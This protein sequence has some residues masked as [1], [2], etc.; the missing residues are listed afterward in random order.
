[1]RFE[2]LNDTKIR[3][4]LTIQDMESNNISFENV[5]SNST[6]SQKLLESMISKAEKEIGFYAE[7]SKLLVEAIM[8]S[9]KECVF[10]IT[11]LHENK[12]CS[13]KC[14][15]SFIFKF[16]SFDNFIDLCIFLKSLQNLNLRN[17]SKKFSLILYNDTYYLKALDADTFSITFD[18]MRTFFSEFGDDVSNSCSID[19]ILNEY[20]K[21]IFEKNA[22]SK[23]IRSFI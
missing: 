9:N 23:C 19:G 17:F 15:K 22:I 18:Y 10:T 14:T 21:I 16:D 3:I 5:L 11:K 1:M 2:K 12:A 7:D 8:T 6:A 13:K 4:I 20:G